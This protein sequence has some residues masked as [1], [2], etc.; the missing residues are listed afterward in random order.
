MKIGYS[1]TYP[2]IG[3]EQ[4][5]KIWCEEEFEGTIEDARKHWYSMKKEVE[6]FHYESNKAAEKEIKVSPETEEGKTIAEILLCNDLPAL[7]TYKYPS[8]QS[9][10]VKAAYNQRLKQLQNGLE[11]NNY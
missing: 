6:N 5:E 1:K 10:A 3:K 8:T 11:Q 7:E 9:K 4:W 2:I